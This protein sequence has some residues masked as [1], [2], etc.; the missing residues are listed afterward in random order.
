M[1]PAQQLEGGNKGRRERDGWML[2]CLVVNP[3]SGI[4][5]FLDREGKID[6]ICDCAEPKRLVA[7]DKKG[8]KWVIK[9]NSVIINNSMQSVARRGG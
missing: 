8:A 7:T 5:C 2:G 3:V 6:L 1:V 9:R 4:V